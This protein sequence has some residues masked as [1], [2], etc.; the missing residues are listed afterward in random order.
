MREM[1]RFVNAAIAAFG[2]TTACNL[3]LLSPLV[4]TYHTALYHWNGKGFSLFLPTILDFFIFWFLA[5]LLFLATQKPERLYIA[6]RSLLVFLL[7][8]IALKEWAILLDRKPHRLSI[9]LFSISAC[10]ACFAAVFWRSRY[11]PA[12]E[13]L[14]KFLNFTLFIS[15]T[16]GALLLSEV[17]WFAWQARSLNVILPQQHIVHSRFLARSDKPL[18]IWIL[19]DELSYQQVYERRYGGLNLP[20]FDGLANESAV[21]THVIPAGIKTEVV[22]PSLMT[23]RIYDLISSSADGKR[24]FTHEPKTDEWREFDQHDTVF[25][26]ALTAG[27][28]TAVAGWYN[29]YCR[30][31]PQVL[32]ECFWTLGPMGYDHPYSSRFGSIGNLFSAFLRRPNALDDA[33]R[34]HISDYRALSAAAD[35][36]LKNNADSFIFIHMPIPHPGGI[37]NRSTGALDPKNSSYLDNL[38][39]ADNYLAHVRSLLQSSGQWDSSTVVIMGDHSWRTASLWAGKAGWTHEEQ[40]A[41]NGGQFDDRPGYIVKLPNQH[42]GIRIDTPFA[43]TKTRSLF[44]QLIYGKIK[45]GDDL[46]DWVARNRPAY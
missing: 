34:D 44:G 37:Y 31:L 33:I 22:L 11:H 40:V 39:L 32:D 18:V 45:S 5:A 20:T 19:L 28:R 41:S 27:Y 3:W 16:V 29:P 14:Q 25:Q 30:I 10:A 26:D 36:M 2:L 23:G 6:I 46:A 43:A 35:Q 9:V 17:A 13:R 12:F 8:W 1:K 7:P 38:V 4:S 15:A 24:L 21:F 42:I